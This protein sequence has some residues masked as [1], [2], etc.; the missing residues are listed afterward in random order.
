[1]G[2]ATVQ[3]PESGPSTRGRVLHAARLYD[4]MAW[5]FMLGRER[6]FREKTL[7]LAW[8]R[9]GEAVLDVGCGTGTLALAAKVRV[10]PRGE[11]HGVD[12]SPEMIARAERKARRADA[13]VEFR[14]G[15]IE[16]LPFADASFDVVLSTLMLHHLPGPTR[17]R[18]MREIRRVLKPGGRVLAVD[19]ATTSREERGIL[20]RVHRRG[21]LRPAK[22]AELLREAGLNPLASG[23]T[24]VANLHFMLAAVPGDS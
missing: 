1:M 4:L 9:T 18:G 13:H 23:S 5:L 3:G 17:A 21:G 6:S 20:S 8:V 16:S 14:V 19:F 24:G 2:Q 15:L 10:G 12:A 7:E 11:V 22:M